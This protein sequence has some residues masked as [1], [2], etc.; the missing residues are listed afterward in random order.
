MK[1]PFVNLG[2]QYAGLKEEILKVFDELSSTGNYVLNPKLKTFEEEFA[3]YCGTKFSVGVGNGTDALFL[4]LLAL[5]VGS[6]DEVITAPNSFIASAGAIGTLGAKPVFVDVGSDYNMDPDKIEAAITPR[7]KA[8]MPVHLT[9]RIADMEGI[10]SIAR[11]HG[12]PVVED[13]AQAVG[14]T[15][16][17]KRAGSFGVTGCFS[18]HPLKNLHVHGDGG[19]ITTD[20]EALYDQF[21]KMRNHGLKNRDECEFWGWNS[22]LDGIQ[23]AIGSLK[24][25]HLDKWNQRFRDIA[26]RYS[27]ELAGVVQV[28]T[29]GSHEQPVY[30]RYVIQH[31]RRDDLMKHLEEQGVETKVNYPI[32]LH[33][34]APARATGHKEGDFPVAEKQASRILSLP[35][36]PELEDHQVGHVIEAVQSFPNP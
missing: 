17:G 22:R 12:L 2:L 35:L 16:N 5:G 9:G 28:P 29:H 4:S 19:M 31:D 3:D 32:P 21:L 6:G 20:D 15:Y 26:G 10:L 14:A 27:K 24:L 30:H 36:Y 7:T 8:L 18:L 23:A 1:V 25:P 11:K 34:Q 33:L 13:S